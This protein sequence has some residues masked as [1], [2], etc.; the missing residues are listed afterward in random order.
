VSVYERPFGNGMASKMQNWFE[1]PV[2]AAVH[3]DLGS[4]FIKDTTQATQSA[5]FMPFRP[6]PGSRKSASQCPTASSPK[7][8]LLA[9]RVTRGG[10]DRSLF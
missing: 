3:G 8:L 6:V 4:V 9:Y 10:Q 7:L 1:S 5:P 2:P